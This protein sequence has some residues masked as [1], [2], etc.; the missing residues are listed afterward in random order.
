M[1][2]EVRDA[3]KTIPRI[4]I[5]GFL[6][7]AGLIFLTLLTFCYHIVDIP[8]AFE[9]STGY[10]GIWVIRQS[11]GQ[12]WL[13]I[14]LV[15]ILILEIFGELAYFAAVS[16]DL[17]AF[18]RDHGFPFS[19]WLAKVDSKRQIPKNAYIFSAG[20]SI[21]LSFIYLVSDLAYYGVTALCTVALLQCYL[22]SIGC[23]MWRRIFHPET[24]PPAR[25]SLGRW[26]LPVNIAAVFFSLWCFFWAFWPE[27]YPVTL[28]VFNWA[29]AIFI[30][31]LLM[32]FINYIFGGRKKY[33]GPVAL[34]AGRKLREE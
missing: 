6:L 4:I 3:A 33:R 14:L 32:A 11:M 1:S 19:E 18:A 13:N 8:T 12:P 10:P 5:I 24:L 15:V 22:F 34:V 27:E 9:D 17:F 25:F 16:R 30:A 23:I 31:T 2:E 20:F 21:L 28:E 29:S 7:N 26:G